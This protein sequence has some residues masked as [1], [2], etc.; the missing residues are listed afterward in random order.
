MVCTLSRIGSEH[1]SGPQTTGT[2]GLNPALCKVKKPMRRLA[3]Q[4]NAKIARTNYHV[5]DSRTPGY[6]EHPVSRT[7]P[8]VSSRPAA[9]QEAELCR[10]QEPQVLEALRG[11]RPILSMVVIQ[12]VMSRVSPGAKACTVLQRAAKSW[13]ILY[14]E[15]QVTI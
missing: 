1:A 15:R 11:H 13:A 4:E 2:A 5:V 8:C 14:L 10:D 9:R 3:R 7:P 12:V 6:L